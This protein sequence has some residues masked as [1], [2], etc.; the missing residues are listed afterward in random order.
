MDIAQFRERF[1]QVNVLYVEDDDSLRKM[2]LEFFKEI[3][4]N[5]DTACDGEEGLKRFKEKEYGLVLSD[6]NMPKMD[7]FEMLK[8]IHELNEKTV[9]VIMSGDDEEID[10]KS[11]I[12][13][14]FLLKPVRFAE[15]IQTFESLQ[16]KL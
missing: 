12:H 5:I 9:L 14:A 16:D 7:G 15:M 6:L 3:F 1:S 8:Q 11:S 2:S 13:D 4:Q 10:K